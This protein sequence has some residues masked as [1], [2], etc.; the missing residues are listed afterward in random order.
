MIY[1][2]DSW[3]CRML[4]AILIV[5]CTT[6]AVSIATMLLG[7][8]VPVPN[9]NSRGNYDPSVHDYVFKPV[10]SVTLCRHLKGTIQRAPRMR[11]ISCLN[12]CK[13]YDGD[14]SLIMISLSDVFKLNR[15]HETVGW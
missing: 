13:L 1:G 3:C 6:A 10:S 5:M 4:E 9:E 11:I 7:T 15:S 14:C 12:L 8:C 2:V